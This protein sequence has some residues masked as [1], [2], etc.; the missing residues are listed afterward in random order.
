MTDGRGGRFDFKG[1]D[2][3]VYNLL[4]TKNTTVNAL[5]KHTDF[6]TDHRLIH[7]SFMTAAYVATKVSNGRILQRRPIRSLIFDHTDACEWH[8][9][10]CF[11]NCEACPAPCG[12]MT[13]TCSMRLVAHA[14]L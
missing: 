13:V 8:Q 5:F 11:E 3:V 2:L 1:K 4:T 10:G 14:T 12:G 6:R 7:G 9:C